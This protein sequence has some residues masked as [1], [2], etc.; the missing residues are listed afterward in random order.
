MCMYIYIYIHIHI[1]MFRIPHGTAD[2]PT[3]EPR[4]LI[5]IAIIIKSYYY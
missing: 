3:R 1:S 5:L 4:A 2:S